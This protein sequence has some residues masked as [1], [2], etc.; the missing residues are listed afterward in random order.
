MENVKNG[1]TDLLGIEFPL[2]VAPMFLV[3]NEAMTI[4]ALQSGV[5][6]CIPAL[7]WRT[8]DAMRQAIA[9]IRQKAKGPIGINLI[10]NKSNIH[11]KRQLATCADLG[12]DYIIT[13]LGSIKAIAQH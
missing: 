13:S 2:I 1:L 10:V 8:D 3:S 5:T 9:T 6:A 12:V 7:N 11:Y 4:A